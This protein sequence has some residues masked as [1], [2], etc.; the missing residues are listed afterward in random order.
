M[1]SIHSSFRKVTKQSAFPSEN[2][3]PK[4]LYLRITELYSK[5]SGSC[6][7]NWAIKPACCQ[8]QI[9][10]LNAEVSKF[11]VRQNNL[12]T[13]LD[14]PDEYLVQVSPKLLLYSIGLSP[15]RESLMRFSRYQIR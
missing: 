8:F 14:I 5:W 9:P 6:V 12:H 10:D 1:E 13:L 3:L 11:N 15:P 2:A 7:Q 4:L